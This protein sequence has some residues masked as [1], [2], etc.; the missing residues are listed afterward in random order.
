MRNITKLHFKKA[1]T[2]FFNMLDYIKSINSFYFDA[3]VNN[4]NKNEH[5]F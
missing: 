2:K 1:D 4:L 5:V 3:A